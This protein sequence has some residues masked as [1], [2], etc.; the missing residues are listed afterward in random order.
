MSPGQV[1]KTSEPASPLLHAA[2][3]PDPWHSAH[4]GPLT[5]P[6]PCGGSLAISTQPRRLPLLPEATLAPTLSW[7][8]QV[9]Q[10]GRGRGRD[11]FRSGR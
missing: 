5:I 9:S 4:V 3:P 11:V 2:R 1:T 10:A 6:P 8:R 7:T